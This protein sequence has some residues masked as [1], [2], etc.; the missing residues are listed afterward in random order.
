MVGHI[1]PE[2]HTLL[3]ISMRDDSNDD[4]DDSS[5]LYIVDWC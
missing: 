3:E 4:N 5:L 1:A 2:S